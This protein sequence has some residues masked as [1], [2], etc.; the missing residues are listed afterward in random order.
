MTGAHVHRVHTH[1]RRSRREAAVDHPPDVFDGGA[2]TVICGVGSYACGVVNNTYDAAG[3][4]RFLKFGVRG[5]TGNKQKSR[6]IELRQPFLQ[7]AVRVRVGNRRQF[8]D[9]SFPPRKDAHKVARR[10]VESG[11][12]RVVTVLACDTCVVGAVCEFHFEILLG[13]EQGALLL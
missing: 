3:E 4:G 2:G 5:S 11:Q 12:Y 7:I 8:V 1:T 13:I 9:V 10:P 6:V